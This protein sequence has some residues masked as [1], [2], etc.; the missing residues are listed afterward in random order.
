MDEELARHLAK[1]AFKS[2]SELTSLYGMI[3]EFCEDENLKESLKKPLLK[4]ISELGSE[5]NEPIMEKYPKVKEEIDE[6]IKK[7]GILIR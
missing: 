6:S 1:T 3:N 2:A 5:F 4:I 7:Y